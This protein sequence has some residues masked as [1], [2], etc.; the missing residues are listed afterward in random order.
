MHL[1]RNSYRCASQKKQQTLDHDITTQNSDA[2]KSNGSKTGEVSDIPECWSINQFKSFKQ[3]YDGLILH[4]EKLGCD[5]CG[6]FAL[7]SV[8]TKG[9]HLSMDRAHC[10]IVVS[11]KNKQIQQASLK[12]KMN[13]HF[14]SQAHHICVNWLQDCSNNILKCIDNLYKKH[15]DFTIKVFNTVYS[16]AKRSRPFCDI[17]HEIELQIENGVDMGVGIHSRKTAVKIVDHIAT[18][19]RKELFTK[20]I[21]KSLKICIIIIDEASTLSSKPVIVIFVKIEDCNF[22]PMIFLDLVELGGQGA[23]EIY[24]CLLNSL[25]LVGFDK[26]IFEK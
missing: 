20:I 3:Q 6:R 4:D 7:T 2:L 25:H 13:L 10:R 22:S 18:Q 16:L 1:L 26:K 14:S 24:S 21:E 23:E 8:D 17:E 5:Y 9:I 11:G 12:K 19:I 15:M